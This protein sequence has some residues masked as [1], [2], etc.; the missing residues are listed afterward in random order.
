M[1]HWFSEN[2]TLIFGVIF[3]L[4]IIF[5]GRVLGLIFKINSI[6]ARELKYLLQGSKINLLDVR[7]PGEYMNSHIPE[8]VNIPLNTLTKDKL[9]ELKNKYSEPVYV[10]CASG[11]RSLWA[12]ISLKKSGITAINVSGGMLFYNRD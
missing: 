12:S 6:S 7:S 3:L 8:A 1:Q 4:T 10:I 9:A 2:S 11:S 5:K